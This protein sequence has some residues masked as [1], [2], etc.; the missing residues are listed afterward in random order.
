MQ[1]ISTLFRF[2]LR[3]FLNIAQRHGLLKC[4]AYFIQALVIEVMH[5]L[6]TFGIQ[7]YQLV[8]ITHGMA[9]TWRE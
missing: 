2:V 3:L 1:A 7:V 5:T 9:Y 4:L 8:V 6:G